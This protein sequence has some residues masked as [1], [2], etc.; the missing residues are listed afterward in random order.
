VDSTSV[1][2]GRWSFEWTGSAYPAHQDGLPADFGHQSPC[3]E[4][5]TGSTL[6]DDKR[7]AA[8]RDPTMVP[9][10]RNASKAQPRSTTLSAGLVLLA[11]LVLGNAASLAAPIPLPVT[12]VGVG[13]AVAGAIA[14]VAMW[15][16]RA[17]ARWAGACIAIASALAASPGL[18]VGSGQ[19]PYVAGATVVIGL[20]SAALLLLPEARPPVR[21]A[22]K[23]V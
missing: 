6:C 5:P 14:I 18:V 23:E 13:L 8:R 2:Y 12:A 3:A 21:S 10:A 16:G 15:T 22:H 11:V 17:R 7:L 1:E 19:A 20:A 9:P 4:E